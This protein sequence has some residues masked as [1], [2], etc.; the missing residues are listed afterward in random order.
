MGVWLSVGFDSVA[1]CQQLSPLPAMPVCDGSFIVNL[2][3]FFPCGLVL[4]EGIPNSIVFLFLCTF[5]S[6]PACGTGN[7]LPTRPPS[8]SC[9]LGHE[10]A[11]DRLMIMC[12]YII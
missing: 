4:V 8:N 2:L 9:V 3:R 11:Y 12:I 10:F 6:P 1:D 5:F 7:V